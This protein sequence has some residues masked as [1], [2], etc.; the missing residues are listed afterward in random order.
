[1]QKPIFRHL[2]PVHPVLVFYLGLFMTLSLDVG[3]SVLLAGISWFCLDFFYS[4][5][6]TES[7]PDATEQ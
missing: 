2:N 4:P 1:M 6:H 3:F 5:I 7:I